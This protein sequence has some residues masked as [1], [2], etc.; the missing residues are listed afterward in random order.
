MDEKSARLYSATRTF[1][2]QNC[3]QN[4]VFILTYLITDSASES[5]AGGTARPIRHKKDVAR[6]PSSCPNKRFVLERAKC[7][8]FALR[9]L[10][11]CQSWRARKKRAEKSLPSLATAGRALDNPKWL[12]PIL[13]QPRLQNREAAFGAP[14][15]YQVASASSTSSNSPERPG[16]PGLLAVAVAF[17][18][19]LSNRFLDLLLYGRR[20]PLVGSCPQ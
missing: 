4:F 19:L 1:Y 8:Y 17:E 11:A 10:P 7:P 20:I 6:I 9:P 2:S 3:P 14:A 12:L 18:N 13:P 5:G 15:F 16:R